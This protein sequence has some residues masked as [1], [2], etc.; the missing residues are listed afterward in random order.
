V[1]KEKCRAAESEGEEG[2]CSN[3]QAVYT[4]ERVVQL[5]AVK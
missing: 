4:A 2:L 5:R 3:K 1:A